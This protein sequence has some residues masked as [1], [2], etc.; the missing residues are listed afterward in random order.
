LGVGD[1]QCAIALTNQ[2][3]GRFTPDQADDR[4]SLWLADPGGTA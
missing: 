1:M 4:T 3:S 2:A